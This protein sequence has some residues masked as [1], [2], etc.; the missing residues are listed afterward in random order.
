[1]DN[2]LQIRPTAHTDLSGFDYD[3]QVFPSPG[4]LR[5]FIFAR[6]EENQRSR[7][8]AGYCWNW[9]SKK[10]PAAHDIVFPEH[11]F[12]MRW[13][14]AEDGGLW[15]MT[16]ESIHV[17][18]CIHTCQGLEL[19]HVGVIVGEDL[20]VRDGRVLT[21]PEKRAR[22]DSSIKG[23]KK[24]LKADPERARAEARA[25]V[26]NTYRT[27]MTRGMKGCGVYCVDQETGEYFRGVLEG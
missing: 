21:Q 17:I 13:N 7:L 16:P 4:E 25:I 6:N 22:H 27:L 12:R 1:M 23:Y 18:G 3:F 5:D 15:I 20:V 19:D 2:A 26:L 14:L 11:D 8:V 10:D 24:R 9:A